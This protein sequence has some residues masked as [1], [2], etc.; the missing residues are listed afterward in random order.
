MRNFVINTYCHNLFL[1]ELLR[2]EHISVVMAQPYAH[3]AATEVGTRIIRNGTD[4][5]YLFRN[6]YFD[7]EYQSVFYLNPVVNV[8]QDDALI[9]K[10][11][12]NTVNKQSFVVV[13]TYWT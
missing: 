5:G 10:C 1:A 7:F 13:S 2:N 11:L 8:T 3:L 12:Y 6:K 9:T 4:L